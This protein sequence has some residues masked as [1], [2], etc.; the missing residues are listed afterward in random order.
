MPSPP[1]FIA[2]ER[3]DSCALACLRMLLAHQGREISEVALVQSADMQAGG[4]DPEE[5][6]AL[7]QQYGFI[8]EVRQADLAMLRDLLAHQ[9]FPIV[10][11]YR[12][13]IDKVAM[14]H[15]MIPVRISRA[16]VTCLDPLRGQRRISIRKFE[17]A[18]QL[19]ANWVLV[20]AW[21]TSE[22]VTQR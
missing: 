19:V 5:L 14:T 21:P 12:Q 9:Q 18:R 10:Y 20:C 8:A 11:L 3:A 13:P 4:L 7:A 22:H 1:P 6:K 16:F 17:Q 2:Q 15:A